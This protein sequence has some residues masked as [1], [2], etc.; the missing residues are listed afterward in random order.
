MLWR[1]FS[2]RR[3]FRIVVDC[4]QCLHCLRRRASGWRLRLLDEFSYASRQEQSKCLFCTF[5]V[6]PEFYDDFVRTPELFVRRFFD[7]VRKFRGHSLKHWFVTERGDNTDRLHLHGIL[8]D[9]ELH[10]D[11]IERL[12]SYGYINTSPL[13]SGAGISYVTKYITKFAD[14]WFVDKSH[15]SKVFCSP[16]IGKRYSEDSR[17]I[18]FHKSEGLRPFML[19]P[20]GS[21]IGM[22]RYYRSKIFDEDDLRAIRSDWLDHLG[23]IPD[24]GKLGRRELTSFE[25]ICT[26]TKSVGGHVVINESQYE[27]LLNLWEKTKFETYLK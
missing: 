13:R 20:D 24:R 8:F 1:S 3:D 4:G 22:P 27:N 18:S 9:C 19:A 2:G 11:D 17:N 21:L 6:R 16:G 23:D 25:Q 15:K 7:R 14:D 5:T 26:A 10:H 12:W